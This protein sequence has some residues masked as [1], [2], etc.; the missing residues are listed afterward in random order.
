M[1]LTDFGPVETTWY[2]PDYQQTALVDG[3]SDVTFG[4]EMPLADAQT[5]WE[6]VNNDAARVTKYGHTGVQ[7]FVTCPYPVVAPFNGYYVFKAMTFTPYRFSNGTLA[8]SFTLQAA[9]L[10]DLA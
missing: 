5:L 6:L 3:I 7:E 1:S 4:G 8:A 10:G 2:N 9:Y